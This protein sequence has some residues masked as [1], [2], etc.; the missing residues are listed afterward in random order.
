MN[1]QVFLNGKGLIH[2]EDAKRISAEYDGVL[3]IGNAEIEVKAN[4][5]CILPNLFYSASGHYDASFK[6]AEGKI[7]DLGKVT[8]RK[9]RILSPPS[10]EVRLAELN[11]RA[12]LAEKERDD[13]R[14]RTEELSKI[15]DTNSLNFLIK[16][17]LV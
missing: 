4:E 1:I 13:L 17:D 8:V 3:T 10:T 12:D 7:Y 16:G 5:E 15:F 2:G 14:L 9:G 6:T 11:C